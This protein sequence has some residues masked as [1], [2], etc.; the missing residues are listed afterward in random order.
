M[1]YVTHR[2]YQ[3]QKQKIGATCP[4][5]LFVETTPGPPER[6]KWY[7][8]LLPPGRTGMHYM[9]Y[10][11]HQMQKHKFDVM[12]PAAHFVEYVPVPP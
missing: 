1:H 4:G 3:M 11:F 6:E 2:S 5:A 8:I 12:C 10:R 9:T 7:I